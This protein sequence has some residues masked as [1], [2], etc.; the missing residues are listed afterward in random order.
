MR[1]ATAGAIPGPDDIPDGAAFISKPFTADVV[2]AHLRK[3][4][5][6]GQFSEPLKKGSD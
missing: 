2:H 3:I 6:E 5:S 1:V 4:V